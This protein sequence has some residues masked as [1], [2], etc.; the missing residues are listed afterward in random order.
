MQKRKLGKSNL[1]VSTLGLGC[2]G[3]SWSYSPVPDR[4]A[5]LSVTPRSTAVRRTYQAAARQK[6]ER[7]TTAGMSKEV[8][9]EPVDGAI[10][11]RIDDANR[12]KY[13]DSAYFTPMIECA[14]ALE[15]SGSCRSRPTDDHR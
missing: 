6:A 14:P 11:R 1:E 2:R 4:S 5:V 9:F 8:T 12:A 7:I 15:Q 10:N 13:H 3:M